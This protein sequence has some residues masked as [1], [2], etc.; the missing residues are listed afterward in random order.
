[1]YTELHEKYKA[2][3]EGDLTYSHLFP[4]RDPKAVKFVVFQQAL[5]KKNMHTFSEAEMLKVEEYIKDRY[6]QDID[7]YDNPWKA[8]KTDET[9]ED[10][11]LERQ[12]L[13]G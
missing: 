12:Y 5:L 10:E 1:L 2:F 4:S 3:T 7:V 9:Q 8:L 6:E 13:I 11:D